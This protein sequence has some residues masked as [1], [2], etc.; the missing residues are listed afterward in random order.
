MK[1]F[2]FFP[3]YSL[4]QTH[5]KYTLNRLQDNLLELRGNLLASGV[6]GSGLTVESQEGTKVKLGLLQ[7]LDLSD[8]NVLQREDGGSGLLNLTAND[9]GNQL[10]GELSKGDV[11]SLSNH[12]FG[13][14]LSDLSNL[15]RLG[16]GSLL[17][18]VGLTLSEGN[19]E[20]SEVVLIR[21][22]DGD[23][24]LNQSLPLADKRSELV[25]SKVQTVEVG[26]EVLALDLVDSQLDSAE[27]VILLALQIGKRD[28]KDT[29]LKLVVG[30]LE[31]GGTVD[32]SLTDITVL[33]GGRSLD[34]V[35]VLTG[36]GVDDSLLDTFLSF[37][38]SLILTNNHF[39]FAILGG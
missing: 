8:V 29:A 12:D 5:K 36:E 13:H 7:Q 2:F 26:E 19:G 22:L 4:L 35:P 21:S 3:T 24:G 33:K 1:K 16:V 18:L 25:G 34:V 27:R 14:L 37:G 38:K 15:G 11:G 30:V 10:G 31:T 17:D 20:D 39:L 6:L 23:I 9:F 32:K 28:V